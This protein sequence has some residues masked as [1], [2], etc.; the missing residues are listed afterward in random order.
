LSNVLFALAT[1]SFKLV[2]S[3]PERQKPLLPPE[4][5]WL[6]PES[7]SNRSFGLSWQ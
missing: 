2:I 4:A 5:R 1:Y 7:R 3:Q 6:P